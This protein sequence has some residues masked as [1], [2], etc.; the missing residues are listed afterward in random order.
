[1]DRKWPRGKVKLFLISK[2]WYK[3]SLLTEIYQIKVEPEKTGCTLLSR[4]LISDDL[5]LGT[6]NIKGYINKLQAIGAKKYFFRVAGFL[7][8]NFGW[9][10]SIT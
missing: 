3:Y 4:A 1:M 9:D 2:N 10:F 7:R 6:E 8:Q 5:G